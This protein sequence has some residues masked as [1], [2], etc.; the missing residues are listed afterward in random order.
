MI[1]IALS[2]T[3]TNLKNKI[4]KTPSICGDNPIPAKHQRLFQLGWELKSPKRSLEALSFGRYGI[5]LVHYY[6]TQP[7]PLELSSDEEKYV[8]S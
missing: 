5:Y 8:M 4:S 3:L 6:S 7:R 2:A 1:E